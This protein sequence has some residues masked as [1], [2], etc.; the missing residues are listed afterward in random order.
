MRSARLWH[1]R[2][3][4]A[5]RRRIWDTFLLYCLLFSRFAVRS[6]T[7]FKRKPIARFIWDLRVVNITWH[8]YFKFRKG[9]TIWYAGSGDMF[10]FLSQKNIPRRWGRPCRRLNHQHFEADLTYR[11]PD[12]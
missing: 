5:G 10:A 12:G 4:A 3:G 7:I 2:P 1:L 11:E 8:M 6:R 9:R